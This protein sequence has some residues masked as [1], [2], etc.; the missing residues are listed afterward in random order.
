MAPLRQQSGANG[1]DSLSHKLEQYLWLAKN[2]LELD[3]LVGWL[4]DWLIGFK[5]N[6][7]IREDVENVQREVVYKF[8]GGRV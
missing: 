5:T 6:F 3:I 8:W 4:V 2:H 1:A 7:N